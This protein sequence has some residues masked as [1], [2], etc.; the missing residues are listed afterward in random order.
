MSMQR[1]NREG[2]VLLT[3]FIT[4]HHNMRDEDFDVLYDTLNIYNCI[5]SKKGNM[6]R[7]REYCA[8]Q[9]TIEYENR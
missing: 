6:Q 9:K 2:I 3:E 8:Q 1:L 5:A 4:T 7:I